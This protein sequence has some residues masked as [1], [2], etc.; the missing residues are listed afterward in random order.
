[1][2]LSVYRAYGWASGLSFMLYVS[3]KVPKPVNSDGY[4]VEISSPIDS[5]TAAGCVL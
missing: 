3:G 5:T 4:F 2:F 1:M